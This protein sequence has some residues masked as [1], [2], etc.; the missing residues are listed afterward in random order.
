MYEYEVLHS[1]HDKRYFD[2]EDMDKLGNAGARF[3]EKDGLIWVYV[4]RQTP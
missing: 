2:Q 4:G 3:E 1:V